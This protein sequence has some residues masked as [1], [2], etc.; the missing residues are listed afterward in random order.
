MQVNQGLILYK[1]TILLKSI[2]FVIRGL[3]HQ[4]GLLS[5]HNCIGIGSMDIIG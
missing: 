1:N 3:I 4:L 2:K 5:C